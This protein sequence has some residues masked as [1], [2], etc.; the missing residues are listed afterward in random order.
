M[1]ERDPA[2]VADLQRAE[3]QRDE[4]LAAAKLLPGRMPFDELMATIER[5]EQELGRWTAKS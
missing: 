4:L 3:R 5:I 2:L 1:S